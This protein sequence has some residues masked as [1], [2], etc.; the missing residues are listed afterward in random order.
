MVDTVSNQKWSMDR[1]LRAREN[2][3]L[4]QRSTDL[5]PLER[6][7][8]RH[9]ILPECSRADLVMRNARDEKRIV[10]HPRHGETLI[11]GQISA[12]EALSA[13]GAEITSVLTDAY[14][15]QLRFDDADRAFDESVRNRRSMIC[16][17]PVVSRGVRV[18]EEIVDR[19][20]RPCSVRMASS[21]SRLSKEIYLAAG[22][23]YMF[24]GPV[25]NLAYEKNTTPEELITH[26][27]Y[28]DRLIGYMEDH[29]CPIVKELP[30]TLTGTLVPPEIAIVSTLI[31]CMLALEQG[32]KRVVCSYGLLGNLIQDVAAI[33]VLREIAEK[34]VAEKVDDAEVYV[35]TPQWMGDF[36]HDEAEAYGVVLNCSM[37]AALGGA[38]EII[39]KSLDE[40]FGVPS[41][42][43]NVA[44]VRSTRRITDMLR[45]QT[46]DNSAELDQEMDLIRRSVQSILAATMEVGSGD[47]AQGTA[48]AI[49]SGIIDVPFSPNVY[50][51]GAS[52]PARDLNGRVRWLNSGNVPL[53]KDI[54]SFHA[55]A[56]AER[57]SKS[58]QHGYQLTIADVTGFSKGLVAARAP[59]ASKDWVSSGL[60]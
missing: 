43:A 30:A 45:G 14:T 20:P 17:Y 33:R 57:A 21:D 22:F 32:V 48:A 4:S 23:T 55:G 15:R 2:E 19:V 25:Q 12:M 37:A 34:M 38:D 7:L 59:V 31:D 8:R 41:T 56:V 36:P 27:Q 5:G 24:M 29:G 42:E 18:T 51:K 52:I 49:R 3:V 40:A 54:A 53:P 60:S 28:E 50:N 39:P 13:A 11:E 9:E 44:G 47:L 35:V 58:G 16:G 46:L 6:T 26:Y 10:V 1:F